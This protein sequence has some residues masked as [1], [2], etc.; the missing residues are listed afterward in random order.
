M[1]LYI[2]HIYIYTHMYVYLH[3]KCRNHHPVQIMIVYNVNPG[4]INSRL[5]IW[6]GTISIANYY[7]L[8]EPPQLINQG[9]CIRG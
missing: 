5:F 1:D 7:C 8:E 6:G 3:I 9:L 4:F 2:I